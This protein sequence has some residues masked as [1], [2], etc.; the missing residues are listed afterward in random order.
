MIL[1]VLCV[2]V[3]SCVVIA[4]VLLLRR[5]QPLRQRAAQLVNE[6]DLDPWNL[7]SH[8][9]R[10]GTTQQ[11]TFEVSIVPAGVRVSNN[12]ALA[13]DIGLDREPIYTQSITRSSSNCAGCHYSVSDVES[14]IEWWN[15]CL[16]HVV[17]GVAFK[18]IGFE[19]ENTPPV[20]S[21]KVL[22]AQERKKLNIGN[23]RI[24]CWDFRTSR[25]IPKDVLMY[26][27]RHGPRSARGYQGLHPVEED[28]LYVGNVYV[29]SSECFSSLST[30]SCYTF[31]H[32]LAHELGHAIGLGHDCSD[33]H[34][35]SELGSWQG[36][37]DCTGM[38]ISSMRSSIKKNTELP[39]MCAD[40]IMHHINGLYSYTAPSNITGADDSIGQQIELIF[41]TKHGCTHHRAHFLDSDSL[42]GSLTQEQWLSVSS[43]TS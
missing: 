40:W 25:E 38:P 42:G 6:K 32:V 35:V 37:F 20:S 41:F 5:E 27:Y 7:L 16:S 31:A 24:C 8:R 2:L 17:N 19:D 21:K 1:F 28:H 9:M 14:A 15:L 34:G 11:V 3:T 30:S 10:M 4:C 26:A 39:P 36:F 18:F 22:S 33:R 29:N 13:G 43:S 12:Q 23:I